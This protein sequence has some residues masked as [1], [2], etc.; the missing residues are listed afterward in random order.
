MSNDILADWKTNRFIVAESVL[1]DFE[2]EHLIVLSD[3]KFWTLEID[4]LIEWCNNNDCSQ[5]GMTVR[6]PTDK[7]L[8]MFI[9]RWSK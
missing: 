6:I 7:L 9:L 3:Y 1:H 8:T 4:N 5:E 2:N